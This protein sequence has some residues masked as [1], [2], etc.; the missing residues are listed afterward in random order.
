MQDHDDVMN[1]SWHIIEVHIRYEHVDN[2]CI[3]TDRWM[4]IG[5]ANSYVTVYLRF[6]QLTPNKLW[7]IVRIH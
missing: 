7:G 6:A 1:M 4:H 2:A 3:A 5:T